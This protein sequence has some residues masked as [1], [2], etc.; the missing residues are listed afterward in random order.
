MAYMKG[1]K[2]D[3]AVGSGKATH[4]PVQKMDNIRHVAGM[5][6]EYSIVVLLVQLIWYT[7][8]QAAHG[9]M[10]FLGFKSKL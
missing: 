6:D 4:L 2:G 3:T 8:D 5:H 9:G 1:A 10:C 7:H